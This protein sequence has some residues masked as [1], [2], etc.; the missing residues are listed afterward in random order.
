MLKL[1]SP[2]QRR[3]LFLVWSNDQSTSTRPRRIDIKGRN[4]DHV[5]RWGGWPEEDGRTDEGAG[6][7]GPNA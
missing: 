4:E 7:I 6:Q 1:T 2:N 5:F 3:V